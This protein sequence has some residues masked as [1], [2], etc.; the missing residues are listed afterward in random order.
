MDKDTILW[1]QKYAGILKKAGHLYDRCRN[2]NSWGMMVS[3]AKILLIYLF[4]LL[5]QDGVDI[6]ESIPSVKHPKEKVEINDLELEIGQYIWESGEALFQFFRSIYK[7]SG[8]N[9]MELSMRDVFPE[10]D[11]DKDLSTE[12]VQLFLKENRE[13]VKMRQMLMDAVSFINEDECNLCEQ[14]FMLTNKSIGVVEDFYHT[15]TD[16]QSD[17]IYGLFKRFYSM[18]AEPV[19]GSSKKLISKEAVVSF[20]FFDSSCEFLHSFNINPAHVAAAI[21]LQ[22]VT[23]EAIEKYH[24]QM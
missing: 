14:A 10:M 6:N 5:K 13:F 22:K 3:Q 7:M 12:S 15:H 4:R 21:F 2:G 24:I 8:W 18:A 1:Y 20:F 16:L 17:E 23:K 19:Y 11:C 9:I